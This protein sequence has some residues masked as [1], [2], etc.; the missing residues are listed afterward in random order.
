MEGGRE[1]KN[2]RKKESMSMN[3]ERLSE[4]KTKDTSE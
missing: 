1:R 2:E 3:Y 4:R